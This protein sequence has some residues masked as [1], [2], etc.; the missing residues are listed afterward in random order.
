MSITYNYDTNTYDTLSLLYER[1][2]KFFELSNHL[3]N[4][5]VSIS[6][7]KLPKDTLGDNTVDHFRADV[8]SAGDYYAFGMQMPNRTYSASE[9]RYSYQGSEKDDEVSGTGNSYTTHFRQYDSR[10]GRWWSYDPKPSASMSPYSSMNANPIWFNDILGDVAGEYWKYNKETKKMEHIGSDKIV[11]DKH[12]VLKE[13][14]TVSSVT[15]ENYQDVQSKFELY[16]TQTQRKGIEKHWTSFSKF[17]DIE[18]K[19][20]S[21]D[22]YRGTFY[23]EAGF[24]TDVLS[25]VKQSGMGKKVYPESFEKEIT[26]ETPS[27]STENVPGS[28][29]LI[30]HFHPTARKQMD[31]SSGTTIGGP[32]NPEFAFK[33]GPSQRDISNVPKHKALMPQG[34]TILQISRGEQIKFLGTKGTTLTIPMKVF[35]VP[36]PQ[37]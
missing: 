15:E 30:Y 12:Y 4:V 2:E 36:L 23:E 34:G 19:K 14:E 6:D 29:N 28:I 5:M 31:F 13:G 16:P 10:I 9:Y 27:L 7:R 20:I 22:Y 26:V 35:F 37:K 17:G 11:D 25:G 33:Q 18:R 32:I 3:G 8:L 1:G 21:G 24:G